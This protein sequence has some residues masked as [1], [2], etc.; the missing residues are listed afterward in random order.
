MKKLIIKNI[1]NS[2][3]TLYDGYNDNNYNFEFYGVNPQKGDILYINETLLNC[4]HELL[5]FG[6]IDGK[7]G[8]QINEVT[9]PDILVLKQNDTLIYLKRYYG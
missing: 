3:Y 4:L 9:D 7:Y 8:R 6:P 5:A 1:K 2:I